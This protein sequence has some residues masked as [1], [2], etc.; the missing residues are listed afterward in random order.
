MEEEVHDARQTAKMRLTAKTEAS[1]I[2]SPM[3][4]LF[5]FLSLQPHVFWV[6]PRYA[7]KGCQVPS[8]VTNIAGMW[9]ANMGGYCHQGGETSRTVIRQSQQLHSWGLEEGQ[10]PSD[11][12]G[13]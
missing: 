10:A 1:T 12:R 7:L 3:F 9:C 6:P 4:V 8:A 11:G 13:Q 2:P 5:C